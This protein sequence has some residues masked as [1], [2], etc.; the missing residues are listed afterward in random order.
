MSSRSLSYSRSE[1]Y[2]PGSPAG[3]AAQRAAVHGLVTP[4]ALT[5]GAR[6]LRLRPLKFWLWLAIMAAM[7][8]WTIT[9]A[10]YFAFREDVLTRLLARQTEMQFG[11]EDRIAELRAQVDRITSR[12][13]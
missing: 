4:H 3:R 1:V 12:Q 13:L 7:G 8:V 10:S 5:R 2:L 11:Y 9:T 6:Q